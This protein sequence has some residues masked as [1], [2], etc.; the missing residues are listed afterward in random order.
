MLGRSHALS[1]A[2]G[3]LAGCAALA[4]LGHRPAWSTVVV[5]AAVS[6]GFAL[7]PDA[8]HP[9]S[10]VARTLGPVT[11][12][13]STG[14]AGAA[15]A[16]RRSSC[17]HC[18]AGPNRG[19]HRALT[20]TAA[21]AL[22][23]GLIVAGLGWWLGER[24]GLALVGFAV[25]LAVHTALSSKTRAKIGDMLLPGR[26]R[27]RGKGAHRFAAAMGAI[28]VAALFT[29]VVASETGPSGWWWV[30]APVAWGCLAHIWG[31]SLTMSRVPAFWP[32][33][34]RGCRWQPVGSPRWM[35]FR[36]GSRVETAVVVLMAVCGF[37]A[38]WVLAAGV[39]G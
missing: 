16:L 39:A 30:G 35:R 2:V 36:T 8:D 32:I 38:T 1:G 26:F 28:I 7:A 12:L 27:R 9:G 5:G 37:A 10:T 33:R 6:T 19:G 4:E 23:A 21:G 25:W 34:I 18:A 22:T 17:A 11:R 13:L 14:I 20:H 15:S 24:A 31:D 29:G 3:W